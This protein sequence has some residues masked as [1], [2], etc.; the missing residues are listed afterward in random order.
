VSVVLLFVL[1]STLMDMTVRDDMTT[2]DNSKLMNRADMRMAQE[3]SENVERGA[4]FLDKLNL[5]DV[6]WYNQINT[7]EI[8]LS[9][10]TECIAGQLFM[11]HV[12]ESLYSYDHGFHY[13]VEEYF[14]GETDV[15]AYC[16][17]NLH[18]DVLTLMSDSDDEAVK[19][20][21]WLGKLNFFAIHRSYVMYEYIAEEW[22]YQIEKRRA[23]DGSML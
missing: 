1:V 16:G 10:G 23:N 21:E 22:V 7:S 8:D 13:M 9:S 20:C 2:Q 14:E 11:D 3:L 5:G 6:P 12:L 15:A 18:P 4:K 19:S 17:F